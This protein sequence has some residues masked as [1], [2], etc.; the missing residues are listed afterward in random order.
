M[1][2]LRD[3]MGW[4]S[5]EYADDMMTLKFSE[6]APIDTK[7]TCNVRRTGLP[8]ELSTGRVE[9]SARELDFLSGWL[10]AFIKKDVEQ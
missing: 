7:D 2:E 8:N 10:R 3:N 5:L 4:F 6:F 9:Q 1:T